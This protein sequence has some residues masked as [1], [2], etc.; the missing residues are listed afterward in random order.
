[1]TEILHKTMHHF[2]PSFPKWFKVIDD[3]RQ[4][5]KIEYPLRNLISIGIFLF[6]LKIEARRQI[7]FMFST[8]EFI[9]N[10]NLFAKTNVDTLAHPD[11]LG[12]LLEKLNP[13]SVSYV[14]KKMIHRLIRMK[15]FVN[16]RL[17][18]QYYLVVIDGTGHM[19]FKERHCP[20]CLT[21]EKHGKILY[22]YHNVLEAKLVLRNGMALSME[23]EFIDNRYRNKKKQDC[24]L[25]AFKRLVKKL[26]G[27]FPQLRICLLLDALYAAQS[28][29]DICTGYKWKYII[30]FKKG[31]MPDTYR[32]YEAL[33]T[34]QV[35][36]KS[37]IKEGKITQ[38]YNWVTDIDYQG[39]HLQ[40]W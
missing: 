38:R 7:K 39:H 8:E 3:P 35:E 4:A 27:D 18:N 31:S 14:I 29:F 21:K 30:T 36:N 32:E 28:V 24:E 33:K 19:V 13:G 12:D 10:L 37:Y 6:L 23:T 26:K 20:H 40:V 11:T 34:L 1:M 2:F 25:R 16:Y 15:C 17:L 5:G 9:K 22:Y